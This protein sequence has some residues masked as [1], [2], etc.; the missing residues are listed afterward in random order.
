MLP[1]LGFYAWILLLV[2]GSEGV[3]RQKAGGFL[4]FT[5]SASLLS[6]F[7]VLCCPVAQ[8][9]ETVVSCVLWSFL[10]VYGKRESLVPVTPLWPSPVI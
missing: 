4:G 5:S 6:D 8:Y 10:A 1:A 2:F 9:L 3:S 7:T